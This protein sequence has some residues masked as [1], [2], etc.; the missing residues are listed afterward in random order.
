MKSHEPIE[1]GAA[2]NPIL[3]QVAVHCFEDLGCCLRD[4]LGL[5]GAFEITTRSCQYPEVRQNWERCAVVDYA[6][7]FEGRITK[8]ST[9]EECWFENC[10]W[11][12]AGGEVSEVIAG[13]EARFDAPKLCA[14]LI[15]VL[16]RESIAYRRR[17]GRPLSDCSLRVVLL[18]MW[19][20]CLLWLLSNEDR[21]CL[22]RRIFGSRFNASADSVKKAVERLG[23]KGSSAF[24]TRVLQRPLGRL[25]I[26]PRLKLSWWQQ[27]ECQKSDSP[28]GQNSKIVIMSR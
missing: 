14:D 11:R 3:R 21:A 19:L 22:I 5:Q 25:D 4:A 18:G 23:L 10:L 7:R 6:R 15:E 2:A 24:A 13:C 1:S 27:E 28:P 8:H 9:E 17:P 16:N 12:F 20:H 26:G